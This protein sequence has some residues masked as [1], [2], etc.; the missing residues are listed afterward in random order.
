VTELITAGRCTTFDI[1]PLR[2]DRFAG[3]GGIVETA[4][5]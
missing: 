4:V 5:L 1:G 2:L 3:T